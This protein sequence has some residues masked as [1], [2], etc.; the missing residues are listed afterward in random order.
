MSIPTPLMAAAAALLALATATPALA[1]L[2]VNRHDD[3][4]YTVRFDDGCAVTYNTT[5]RRSGSQGCR[6]K[7][8][9]RA[10][11]AVQDDVHE[12]GGGGLRFRKLATGAA[13]VTF[14]DGCLVTYNKE[15]RRSGSQGCHPK[16][17][18]RADQSAQKNW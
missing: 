1:D 12:R 6:P 11:A 15:G 10:D 18:A 9:E 13:T 3:G 17:V 16:Q 2:K 8:V 7:Q 5:G 14:D 4:A